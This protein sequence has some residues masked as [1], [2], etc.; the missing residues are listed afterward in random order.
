MKKVSPTPKSPRKSKEAYG[1]KRT[2]TA[3][4]VEMEK[5]VDKLNYE[6]ESKNRLM[7]EMDEQLEKK[8]SQVG[9][10]SVKLW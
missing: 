9:D 10:M 4:T 8:Q 2:L 6:L 7:V 1:N 3:R 5:E